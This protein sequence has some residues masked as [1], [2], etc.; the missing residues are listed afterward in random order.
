MSTLLNNKLNFVIS[1]S[2]YISNDLKEKYNIGYKIFS[3]LTFQIHQIHSF[4]PLMHWHLRSQI[5]L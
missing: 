3:F 2:I 4:I 1:T 5:K